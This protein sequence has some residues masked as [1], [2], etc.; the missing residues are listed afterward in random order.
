MIMEPVM[1]NTGVITPQPGYLERARELC[2]RHGVVL[3]YDEII[4]GFRLGLGG[5]QGLFGV[6]PDLAVFA[7]ALASGFPI[8][9]VA[10]RRDLFDGVADG[11]ILH[12]GT[13]NGYPVGLAA[14]AATIRTLADPSAGVY[15][16]IDA[17]GRQLMDGFR[18]IATSAP[19]P[20]HVTGLPAMSFVAFTDAPELIDHRDVARL[21][22][23]VPKTFGRLMAERGI[24]VHGRGLWLM[25]AAHSERDIDRTLDAAARLDPGDRSGP[26]EL[27]PPCQIPAGRDDGSGGDGNRLAS[28]R[29]VDENG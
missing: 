9:A 8:A 1:G 26:V 24:R 21:E 20:M 11:S 18:A 3:I 12:G 22:P 27:R 19:L 23:D 7:K 29:E 5:A 4:T 16:T 6:T 17:R 25:S 13:F 14:A 2:T 10:G 28:L 15:E